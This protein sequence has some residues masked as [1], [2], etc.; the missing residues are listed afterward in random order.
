MTT[1]DPIRL[2]QVFSNLLS[3]A[4][5]FTPSNGVVVVTLRRCEER[6]EAA[7][8]DTGE[9]IDS[10]FL[11]L[12][13]D[14]FRQADTSIARKHGGLGLGLSI[15]K[16]LVALHGGTV[17][18]ESPGL[19]RGATFIV[20][21]P[22]PRQSVPAPKPAGASQKSVPSLHG[23]RVLVVEDDPDSR[24]LV[25]KLLR[26][27]SA[28][29]KTVDSARAALQ[30]L[31]RNWPAVLVCDI[32]MP[33]QDGYSLLKEIKKRFGEQGARLPSIALTAFARS[34]DRTRAMDMGFHLHMAKPIEPA[35]LVAGVASLLRLS[36]DS[37][38][39]AGKST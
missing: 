7:V 10:G 20:S 25:G 8:R 1:G 26:E 5:R 21:L 28:D 11:P 30:W 39:D 38:V 29:V 34:E 2:Q 4:L 23:A 9:G 31:E 6:F 35:E 15:V 32:A 24:D 37:P 36:G 33:E 27:K 3:N 18:A 19:G 17:R 16:E 13:F 12:I 14:R 22:K